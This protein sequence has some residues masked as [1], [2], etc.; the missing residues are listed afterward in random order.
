MAG[1]ISGEDL[2]HLF[3]D[4]FHRVS[5]KT[6]WPQLRGTLRV[7][8]FKNAEIMVDDRGAVAFRARPLGDDQEVHAA[9]FFRKYISGGDEVYLAAVLE[10]GTML[11]I[12]DGH[13]DE[14]QRIF[15]QLTDK[16]W[17]FRVKD[18]K[19]VG[20]FLTDGTPVGWGP[21]KCVRLSECEEFRLSL[22]NF[23]EVTFNEEM[24]H[25]FVPGRR[26]EVRAVVRTVSEPL[27]KYM[28][29][30]ALAGTLYAA[31]IL[32]DEFGKRREWLCGESCQERKILEA[33]SSKQSEL[34]LAP[35]TGPTDSFGLPR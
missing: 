24:F 32:H 15:D 9:T 25:P 16:K 10:A 12:T 11:G 8:K 34:G 6:F 26:E 21:D 14:A 29:N 19:A 30:L 17:K 23:T 18:G 35:E 2:I 5:Q 4:S 13:L 20:M 7:D 1:K 28:S 22:Q 3:Q 33:F 31:I 27:R